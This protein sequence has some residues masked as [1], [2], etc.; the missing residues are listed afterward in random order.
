MQRVSPGARMQQQVDSLMGSRE[1]NSG[2]L[3]DCFLH[4]GRFRGRVRSLLFNRIVEAA[5]CA[6][7]HHGGSRM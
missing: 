5:G 3:K 6:T 4:K 2:E 7:T 1:N